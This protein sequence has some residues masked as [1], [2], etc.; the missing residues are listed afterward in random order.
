[1]SDPVHT[2][3]GP[4]SL[5][6]DVDDG[7]RREIGKLWHTMQ[8]RLGYLH[9]QPTKPDHVLVTQGDLKTIQQDIT[10]RIDALNPTTPA[11][12]QI[13]G[14][15]GSSGG[16]LD[17]RPLDNQW[18]G[19]N[20]WDHAD[21]ANL[22]PFA[23]TSFNSGTTMIPPN[24]VRSIMLD[25]GYNALIDVRK[26][27][28]AQSGALSGGGNA[29]VYVQHRI[30][31]TVA[32]VNNVNSGIRVQL[33][34]WQRSSAVVNDAVAGYFGLYNHGFNSGGFG[35]HV[36]AYHAATGN[37]VTYGVDVE[38]FREF[39]DG[40]TIAFHA[41]AAADAP[42][43]NVNDWAYLASPQSGGSGRFK[44]AF[45]AGSDFIGALPCD[46]GLDLGFASCSQFAVVLPANRWLMWN[47]PYNAAVPVKARFNE[48]GWIEWHCG[49]QDTFR[50][51][52]TGRIHAWHGLA[53]N[54]N[55][56][57]PTPGYS[58]LE[59]QAPGRLAWSLG[60]QNVFSVTNAG[61]LELPL[62]PTYGLSVTGLAGYFAM[63]IQNT[64]V[65]VP[66]YTL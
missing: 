66:F 7:V 34:T 54:N 32:A 51:D 3:E 33:E 59:W 31:T 26:T 13:L 49:E 23:F 12:V 50:I 55:A 65:G 19:L 11:S 43:G 62:V 41:R 63:I 4:G 10:R 56:L 37:G 35:V 8:N 25:T 27:S 57:V 36:D 46:I 2:D 5:G 48:G 21:T 17:L 18:T 47:G 28:G 58:V 64:L 24:A 15:G 20:A 1:V 45:G 38:L 60:A 52:N 6:G 16:G 42:F 53:L 14:D 44:V 29:A 30:D 9:N 40:K 39:L 22:R 61:I